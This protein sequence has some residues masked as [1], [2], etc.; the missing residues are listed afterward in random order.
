MPVSSLLFQGA[1]FAFLAPPSS[2]AAV[3][4]YP[5]AVGERLQ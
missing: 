1:L 3:P 5:F 4:S 2:P